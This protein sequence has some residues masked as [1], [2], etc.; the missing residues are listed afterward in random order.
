MSA[1]LCECL[2]VMPIYECTDPECGCGLAYQETGDCWCGHD[3]D[4]HDEDGCMRE[5]ES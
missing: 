5:V 1:I 2:E 4:D 3:L